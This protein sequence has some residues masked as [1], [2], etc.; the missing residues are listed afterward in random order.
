MRWRPGPESNRCTG[1]CSPLH[2]HSATRPKCL[3]DN[4]PARPLIPMEN[5]GRRYIDGDFF[6][7][8]AHDENYSPKFNSRSV[9]LNSTSAGAIPF[10]LAE[11]LVVRPVAEM[12]APGMGCLSVTGEG[13]DYEVARH[14]MVENQVRANKVTDPLVVSALSAVPRE[15]FLPKDYKDVAYADEDIAIGG[16]RFLMEPMVFARLLQLASVKRD[17]IALDVGCGTGYSAAVLARMVGAVVALECD[18]SLAKTAEKN[19]LDVGADNAAVVTG[20]LDSGHAAQGPYDVIII[21]G[22]VSEVP[23][24]LLKQ[25]A[26]G[27]R[28]VAVVRGESGVGRATLVLKDGKN[29]GRRVAFD[30][31]V[32]HLPGFSATEEFR[33]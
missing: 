30:A 4:G 22:A 5:H 1:I 18:K 26:K 11:T 27:G 21:E 33:F 13:M 23:E 2:D 6:A 29:Y 25:L 12:I 15:V 10:I 16:G 24:K 8:K 20:A 9:A 17:D 31:A 32:P 7:V 28:L 3:A 14:K 19:L